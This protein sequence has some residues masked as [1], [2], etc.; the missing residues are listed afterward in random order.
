MVTTRNG[1]VIKYKAED[2]G[3]YSN[4]FGRKANKRRK[5]LTQRQIS[6]LPPPPSW[7]VPSSPVKE[8]RNVSRLRAS[9]KIRPTCS[10]YGPDR[11][12]RY[13]EFFSVLNVTFG[14]KIISVVRRNV[15]LKRIYVLAIMILGWVPHISLNPLKQWNKF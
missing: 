13:P 1:K 14:T 7:Q 10:D 6:K 15:P 4:V 11:R 2:Y 12:I 3:R 5:A 8:Q 9:K